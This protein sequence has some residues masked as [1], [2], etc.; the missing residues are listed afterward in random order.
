MSEARIEVGIIARGRIAWILAIVFGAIV[1]I[2]GAAL[3]A[4]KGWSGMHPSPAWLVGV[5]S[6]FA[7][8]GLIFLIASYVTK[9]QSD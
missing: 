2:T 7:V 9:G 4:A 6:A 1:G 8:V 3:G 5:G